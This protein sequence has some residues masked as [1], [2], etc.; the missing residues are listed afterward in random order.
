MA[1]LLFLTQRIPCPPIKGEKIRPLQILRKLARK[2]R[3]HLGTLIAEPGGSL[4]IRIRRDGEADSFE[5]YAFVGRKGVR[6]AAN[7]EIGLRDEWRFEG[8]APGPTRVKVIGMEFASVEREGG[9][10]DLAP[11][12][13]V[14]AEMLVLAALSVELQASVGLTVSDY[15][16]RHPSGA[17]GKKRPN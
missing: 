4:V 15:Q 17:L 11:R 5:A 13:S 14:L 8:L 16:R 7:A 3:V 12:A 6:R 2:Y 9:P 10:L 1:D